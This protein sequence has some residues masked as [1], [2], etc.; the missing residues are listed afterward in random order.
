V[1]KNRT[2]RYRKNNDIKGA[3]DKM[4][5]RTGKNTAIVLLIT[6]I[7]VFI[8]IQI[9][10]CVISNADA[11]TKSGSGKKLG[12]GYIDSDKL[13]SEFPDLIKFMEEKREKSIEMRSILTGNKELT[14][15]QSEKI[16]IETEKFIQLEN[17]HLLVFVDTIKIASARVAD[18]KKLDIIINN[19]SSEKVLEYGGI[20]VTEDVRLKIKELNESDAK[21]EES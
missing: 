15:E 10:G 13:F 19:K 21:S 3:I 1:S 4:I 12:I 20:D 18:D 9:T 16:A 2:I 5:S 11:S 17:Q 7:V 6:I 14:K 8:S